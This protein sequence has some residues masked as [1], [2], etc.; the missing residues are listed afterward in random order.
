VKKV[1]I[2]FV[3]AD[4]AAHSS[5]EE[6]LKA[7]LGN[8]IQCGTHL[9]CA[10]I[11]KQLADGH[12]ANVAHASIGG[13]YAGAETASYQEG[14][15]DFNGNYQIPNEKEQYFLMNIAYAGTDDRFR[16]LGVRGGNY[17]NKN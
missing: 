9:N 13:D 8:S 10:D 16:V 6:A 12:M 17:L 1:D 15:A 2:E 14:V 4:N 5:I 3:C 7:T 11:E